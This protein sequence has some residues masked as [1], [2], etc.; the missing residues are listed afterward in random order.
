MPGTTVHGVA[1][2]QRDG[3][4]RIG[5][6]CGV[7]PVQV[8]VMPDGSDWTVDRAVFHRTARRLAEGT[9]F[10]RRSSVSGVSGS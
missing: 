7:M 6:P 10:I 9:A 5:H 1:G 8:D 4:I 3:E 2:Q